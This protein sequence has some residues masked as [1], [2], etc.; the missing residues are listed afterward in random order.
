MDKTYPKSKKIKFLLIAACILVSVILILVLTYKRKIPNSYK[1]PVREFEVFQTVNEESLVFIDGKQC[2]YKIPKTEKNSVFKFDLSMSRLFILNQNATL[3]MINNLKEPKIVDEKVSDFKV[4]SNGKYV[5]YIN[6]D[7]QLV[8]KDVDT[9]K[10]RIIKDKFG[11]KGEFEISPSGKTVAFAYKNSNEPIKTYLN[12]NGREKE[13][14]KNMLPIVVSDD[15]TKVFLMSKSEDLY[16]LNLNKK[17]SKPIKLSEAPIGR[18][19]IYFNNSLTEVVFS[20]SKGTYFFTEDGKS[21]K[22]IID[23]ESRIMIPKR[24]AESYSSVPE[25]KI[26][27]STST[28]LK[29]YFYCASN[30]IYYVDN[31]EHSK[32]LVDNATQAEITDNLD[33]LFYVG[34]DKSLH[35]L[36][37]RDPENKKLLAKD[38]FNFMSNSLGTAYYYTNKDGELYY[39]YKG[40][41]PK[42][43]A[44]KVSSAML[45]KDGMLIYTTVDDTNILTGSSYLLKPGE[46]PKKIS[47]N[48]IGAFASGKLFAYFSPKYEGDKSDMTKNPRKYFNEVVYELY[49]STNGVDFVKNENQFKPYN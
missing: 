25:Y 6:A 30:S 47:E 4:S 2:D 7:K 45:N 14:A 35:K 12:T 15:A 1:D 43:M 46:K 39:S 34:K 20:N 16:Y 44:D 10:S 8:L 42:K 11:E 22:K 31:I 17:R 19:P 27:L 28:V 41:E 37:K 18:Y 48:S 24:K 33:S 21:V 23:E 40:E 9:D 29:N 5:T 13:I 26:I 32:K 36:F 3:Y 38:C 49:T